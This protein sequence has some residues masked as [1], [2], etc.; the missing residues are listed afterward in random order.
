MVDFALH[1]KIARIVLFQIREVF[2]VSFEAQKV[3]AKIKR[4]ENEPKPFT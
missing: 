2:G 1:E 3:M 4:A